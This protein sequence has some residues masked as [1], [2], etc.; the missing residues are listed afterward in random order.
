MKLIP[1]LII[2]VT[3]FASTFLSAQVAFSLEKKTQHTIVIEGMKFTPAS[4]EVAVGDTVV[5]INKDFFPHTATASNKLFDS[6][7]I[8]ANTS[9]KHVLRKKGEVAYTCTLHPMMKGAITVK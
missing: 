5:W 2:G 8:K 7:E 3:I 9:W 6:G 1:S 4:L